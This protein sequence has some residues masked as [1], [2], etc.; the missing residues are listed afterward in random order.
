MRVQGCTEIALTKLDVLG[1]LDR[2]PVCVAYEVDGERTED[3][4]TGSRLDRA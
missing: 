4:P 2:V 3:F 1:C